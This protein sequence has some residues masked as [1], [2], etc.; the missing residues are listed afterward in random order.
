MAF[1][2]AAY[3]YI[4]AA[5]AAVAAASA[6]QQGRVASAN[7]KSQANVSDYNAKVAENNA[8]T[9]RQQAVANEEGQR[10]QAA[11][12]LG[13]QRAGTAEA[14]GGLDGTSGDLYAQ[15]LQNVDLDAKNILYQ[16]DLRG[17][18][19]DSEATLQTAGAGQY[20]SNAS[21]AVSGSYYSAAGAALSG[22]GNYY[23]TTALAKVGQTYP[24]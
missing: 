22:A 1:I 10:R 3:P 12:Q 8:A 17:Q 14:G 9:S 7:A 23:K 4:M 6:I 20:R 2:A 19:L 18:G 13:R 11:L 24:G 15:S 5:G 21:Q 16:G